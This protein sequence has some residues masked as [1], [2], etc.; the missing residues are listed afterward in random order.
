VFDAHR[1]NRAAANALL[2]TLEEPPA[3]A[4]I[5]LTT[6]QPYLLPQTILSRCARVN[7][8]HL[9]EAELVEHLSE[10]GLP[11]RE[12]ASIASLCDGNARRA[13]DL[14][15]PAAREMADWGHGVAELLLQGDKRAELLKRAEAIAKGQ[16]G[17]KAAK[18]QADA[19]LA[20]SRD[21]GMRV[22][23]TIA[24]ELATRM[25]AGEARRD[26]PS[27]GRA[28]RTLLHAREDL[29]RNVNVALVLSDAFQRACAQLSADDGH[30]AA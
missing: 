18:S 29:Q 9:P 6:H 22:L 8:P 19:G 28:I 3:H 11:R 20:A 16:P 21:V 12:A 4:N 10:K 2:K 27:L 17:G 13:L 24:A 25:R 5:V 23:D 7:M 1:M 26:A 30:S 15:D 14:L